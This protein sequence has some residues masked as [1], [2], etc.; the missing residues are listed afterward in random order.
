MTTRRKRP[1]GN[2]ARAVTSTGLRVEAVHRHHAHIPDPRPGEHMWTVVGM[3]RI[4]NPN[5]GGRIDLDL[6]NLVTLEGP[7]CFVCEQPYTPELAAKP[8]AGEPR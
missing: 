3:W 8:C 1:G 4:A 5:R 2:P 7:G 6:E